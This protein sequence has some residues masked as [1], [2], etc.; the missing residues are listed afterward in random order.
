MR[1]TGLVLLGATATGALLGPAIRVTRDRGRPLES[2]LAPLVIA[3][4]HPSAV[5]R[6]GEGRAPM[7]AGL[8]ADLAFARERVDRL[9][10]DSA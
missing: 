10:A 6:A 8:V 1:P 4:I 9:L 3:T 2:T 7:L 5:L